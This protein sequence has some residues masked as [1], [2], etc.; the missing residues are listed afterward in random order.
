[1]GSTSHNRIRAAKNFFV[2]LEETDRWQGFKRWEKHFK[3]SKIELMT[4]EEKDE[5]DDDWSF[6]IDELAT[7]YHAANNRMKL[8]MLLALNTAMTQGEIAT[9]SRR[10][11]VTTQ[12]TII[13]NGQVI[14]PGEYWITK[15]RKKVKG[16]AQRGRWRLWD[17]TYTMSSNQWTFL[18]NKQTNFDQ[19]ALMFVT[20]FNKPLVWYKRGDIHNSGLRI[21]AV[22]KSWDYLLD[23][24]PKVKRRSF[25][26]LRKT[27]SQFVRD[28]GGKELSELQ[29]VH[30]DT[31]MGR[32]YNKGDYIKLGEVLMQVRKKLQ[33]MFE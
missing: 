4:D 10:H 13:R 19:R 14:Q 25:K 15:T 33:P 32:A 9:L 20:R 2:W 18:R 17:E 30:T 24:T 29:L 16:K 5:S 12:S 28:I 31:T 23:N 1:M 21:D 27:S 3:V 8:L 6:T 7:L 26:Y 11:F 22:Q